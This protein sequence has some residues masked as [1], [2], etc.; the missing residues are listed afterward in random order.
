[1]SIPHAVRLLRCLAIAILPGV[2]ATCHGG[3]GDSNS[4]QIQIK[5]L[6]NRAD[7][8][9]GGNSYVEIVMPEGKSIAG[10]G[11]SVSGRDVTSAF[12]MRPNGRIL[13][14][15]TGLANG[16]NVVVASYQGSAAAR[17]TITNHPIGGPVI[18]GAQTQPFVCATP[19]PLP[20]T[21]T[22]PATNGSGLTGT[23]IDAQSNL[24]TEIKLYY[25]SKAAL[26]ANCTVSLPDPN[27][28]ANPPANGCVQTYDPA[29]P[30]PPAHTL[31]TTTDRGGTVPHIVPV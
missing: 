8:I 21:A 13:G 30:P 5:T 14:V 27:P 4:G 3:G 18:S 12:A 7:L 19:A 10:W 23:A 1:M 2:L 9:S 28:P 16:D 17:L 24:P 26:A 29:N 11:V 20:A 31:T 15:I 25:K 6:S 22:S